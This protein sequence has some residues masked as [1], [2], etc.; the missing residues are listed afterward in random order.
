MRADNEANPKGSNFAICSCSKTD[1]RLSSPIGGDD[2][3]QSLTP[4]GLRSQQS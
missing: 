3:M 2:K 1:P 4:S